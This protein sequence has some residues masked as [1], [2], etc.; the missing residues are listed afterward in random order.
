M[1]N[2]V[3]FICP[4]CG[5]LFK[6]LPSLRKHVHYVHGSF[7]PV[8]GRSIGYKHLYA[9]AYQKA[10]WG[11]VKHKVLWALLPNHNLDAYGKDFLKDCLKLALQVCRTSEQP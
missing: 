10:W 7:C 2:R 6:N 1:S 5:S 9:H 11:D 4:Y 8:C 3:S